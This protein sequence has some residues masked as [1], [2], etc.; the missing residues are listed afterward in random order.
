MD[1]SILNTIKKML[2]FDADYTAFDTDIT[3]HI[4]SVFSVM[5]QLGATPPAGFWISD[6][7]TKWSDFI[8]GRQH[9]EMVK[10]YMYFKVRL[11]FDP[12]A[13]SFAIDAIK[14]Q[15]SEFE[16]RL[17]TLEFTFNPNPYVQVVVLDD[18]EL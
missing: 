18:E 13:T 1:D 4:N 15:I 6:A 12:P 7:A 11:M 16:W 10:S 5:H 17:N 8:E 3:M 9:V 14:Q 2:G